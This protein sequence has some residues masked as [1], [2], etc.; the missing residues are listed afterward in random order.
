MFFTLMHKDVFVADIDISDNGAVTGVK[1]I[2]VKEHMPYG[3]LLKDFVDVKAFGDWWS[4]RSIPASRS[5]IE[6]VM[7]EL[8]LDNISVLVRHSMGLSLSDHYWFR[9]RDSEVSWADVNFF[10]N[11]FSDDVGDLLFGNTFVSGDADLMSPDNTCDGVLRKRWKIMDGRRRLIKGGEPPYFQEPY[12]E[13]AASGIMDLLDIPH[14]EYSLMKVDG[15]VCCVCDDF[16]DDSIEFISASRVMKSVP[17][18]N[19]R[20]SYDHYRSVCGIHGMDMVPF[21]DKMLAVDHIIANH[22]RHFNNFGILRDSESLEWRGPAPIFDSGTSLGSD[23]PTERL[24]SGFADDSKPFAKTFSEQ[25]KLISS[26]DWLNTEA[27]GSIPSLLEDVF[28]PGNGWEFDR[29]T[30]C[31]VRAVESRIGSLIELRR[32]P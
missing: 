12:N 10:D 30:E 17:K 21:I 15:D 24:P 6:N 13:V 4:G 28:S 26:L 25:N 31:I 32:S 11:D 20:S 9:P 27:L 3:T 22:D 29:R 1:N 18:R 14:A 5:G 23:I 8:G 16:V 19:D 7:T 2:R